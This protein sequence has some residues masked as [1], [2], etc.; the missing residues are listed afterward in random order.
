MKN[1]QCKSG[2]LWYYVIPD[3]GIHGFRLV[4]IIDTDAYFVEYVLMGDSGWNYISSTVPRSRFLIE[5]S[6]VKFTNTVIP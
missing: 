6:P 5:F 4:K 3:K 2:E 1:N